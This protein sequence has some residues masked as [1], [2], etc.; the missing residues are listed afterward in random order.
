MNSFRARLVA[1][2]WIKATPYLRPAHKSNGSSAVEVRPEDKEGQEEESLHTFISGMNKE[3]LSLVIEQVRADIHDV[4]ADDCADGELQNHILYLQQVETYM[5]LRYAIC[6]GDIGLLT[7]CFARATVLFHGS[8]KS[9]YAFE[10][11][12]LIWLT[13]T[14]AATDVL[15]R[16]ILSMSV[17]NPSGLPN[18]FFG[19]DLMS[20][21]LNGDVKKVIR[22]RRTSTMS[23]EFVFGYACK[24]A[25]YCKDHFR[26]MRH[27]VGVQSNNKQA[28]GKRA[29]DILILARDHR[30]EMVFRSGPKA[31]EAAINLAKVGFA[32]LGTRVQEFNR[33]I[34]GKAVVIIH[35]EDNEHPFFPVDADEDSDVEADAG[36]ENKVDD[37]WVRRRRARDGIV[38]DI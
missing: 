7:D 38:E 28:P 19:T 26:R 11:L 36:A 13:S 27:F 25:T 17:V 37:M 6:N 35:E 20:E 1:L 31:S 12:Y 8:T 22:D 23:I 21:Y 3:N 33:R 10:T 14:S 16:V 4:S 24:F 32:R 29:A 30:K 2:F 18:K 34:T 15:K 5:L 9:K